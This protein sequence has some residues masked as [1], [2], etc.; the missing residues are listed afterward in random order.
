MSY[1]SL[2]VLLMQNY[3]DEQTGSIDILYTVHVLLHVASMK[4]LLIRN[5]LELHPPS[6]VYQRTKLSEDYHSSYTIYL[7]SQ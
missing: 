7:D 2:F 5:H 1:I 4:R 6:V 3:V